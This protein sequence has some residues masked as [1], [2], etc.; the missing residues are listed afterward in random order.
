MFGFTPNTHSRHYSLDLSLSLFSPSPHRAASKWYVVHP[1]AL[2]GLTD[3]L[4]PM[5]LQAAAQ[6][7][8]NSGHEDMI[9]RTRWHARTTLNA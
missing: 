9:V 6:V 8:S 3:G 2:S 1:I 4:F 7:I 5:N